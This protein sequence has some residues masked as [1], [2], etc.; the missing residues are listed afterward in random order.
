MVS[1]ASLPPPESGAGAA[2][3]WA[4]GVEGCTV[5]SS[6]GMAGALAALAPRTT[7]VTTAVSSFLIGC[8]RAWGVDMPRRYGRD[9]R[10]ASGRLPIRLAPG[11]PSF[12]A[13]EQGRRYLG[14][15]AAAPESPVLAGR[16]RGGLGSCA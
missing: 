8:L 7:T 10:L 9:A 11:A 5:G 1:S 6:I 13:A 16:A 2:S 14:D 3:G 12:A 15:G 4:A